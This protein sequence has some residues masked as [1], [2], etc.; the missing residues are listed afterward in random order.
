M[1]PCLKE[2]VKLGSLSTNRGLR[3]PKYLRENPPSINLNE[4]LKFLGSTVVVLAPCSHVVSLL[5]TGLS[6]RSV[7][8][9]VPSGPPW[10]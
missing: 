7:E 1:R 5:T 6:K 2:K 10:T 8:I 9:Q 4:D 3:N